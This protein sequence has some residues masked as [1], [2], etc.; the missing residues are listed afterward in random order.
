MRFS[1]AVTQSGNLP[2]D[3]SLSETQRQIVYSFN[4]SRN[5]NAK[6]RGTR[7]CEFSSQ[8]SLAA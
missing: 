1:L 5:E 4:A 2:S 7:T 6:H 8:V 3:S